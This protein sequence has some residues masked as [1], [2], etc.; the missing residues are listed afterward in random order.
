M[1]Q[2]GFTIHSTAAT[3]GRGN[4][5]VCAV[6]PGT[7]F[8]RLKDRGFFFQNRLDRP[9]APRTAAMDTFR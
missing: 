2:S 9:T 3:R 7:V 1:E 4:V 6:V 5:V 8:F